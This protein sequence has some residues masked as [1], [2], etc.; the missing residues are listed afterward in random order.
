MSRSKDYETF[1]QWLRRTSKY[2]QDFRDESRWYTLLNRL[3]TTVE[4]GF[5]QLWGRV[6]RSKIDACVTKYCDMTPFIIDNLPSKQF[7]DAMVL[8]DSA[9]IRLRGASSTHQ[10]CICNECVEKQSRIIVLENRLAEHGH[11][12]TEMLQIRGDAALVEAMGVLYH[13]AFMHGAGLTPR[14]EV[15]TVMISAVAEHLKLDIK[16]QSKLWHQF[17]ETVLNDNTMYAVNTTK[18]YK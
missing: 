17:C 8:A 1:V 14:Y 11:C 2:L 6:P 10:S 9:Q 4:E 15:K 5:P 16:G 7:V 3:H 13:K 18:R 12:R